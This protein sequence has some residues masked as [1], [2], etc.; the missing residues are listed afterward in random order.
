ME[1]DFEALKLA[2][3]AITVGTAFGTLVLIGVAAVLAANFHGRP[4]RW[5]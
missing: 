1:V 3:Y 5:E 2:L 4:D